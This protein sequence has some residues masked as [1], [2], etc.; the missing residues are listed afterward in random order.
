[1]GSTSTLNPKPWQ[2]PI[3]Q[4]LGRSNRLPSGLK[5][6]L[7]NCHYYFGMLVVPYHNYSTMGTKTLWYLGGAGR[8]RS[9]IYYIAAAMVPWLLFMFLL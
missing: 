5:R 6:D 9:R 1:M 8:H 4:G 3:L 2:H 7:N